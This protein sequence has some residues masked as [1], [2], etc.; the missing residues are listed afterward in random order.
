MTKEELMVDLEEGEHPVSCREV[1]EDT[2]GAVYGVHIYMTRPIRWRMGEHHT[3]VLCI[4]PSHQV[5][6][7]NTAEYS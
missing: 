6:T 1:V 3:I 5:Y 4:L 2:S 7:R